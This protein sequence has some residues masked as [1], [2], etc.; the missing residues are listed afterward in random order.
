MRAGSTTARTVGG[1]V[2]LRAL[3]RQRRRLVLAG[4]SIALGV[5][6]LAGALG[7]L[8][9]IGAGLDEL[10]ATSADDADVVIEGD[11][12]YESS[13]E[14]VRRLVPSALAASAAGVDGVESVSHRLEDVALVSDEQG[15]PV[16]TPG[17]S[18]Q[19]RGTNWPE[20]PEVSNL[21]LLEGVAPS[22]DGEVLLDEH[23]AEVA[24]VGTGDTVRVAGK[25]KVG[26][27]EVSGLVASSDAGRS[28]GSS[29]V[30]LSTDEAR[31]V[32]DQPDDDNRIAIRL[33]PD[34]DFEEV[35]AALRAIAPPGTEVTDGATAAMH[36]TESLTRSFVVVRMLVTA[37]G[38]L[39]LLVGTVTVAN[40]LTLLHSQRRRMFAG[41]R[42]AGAT[43]GQ[44]RRAA[45]G[46]AVVLAAVSSVLG[47]PLGV[48]LA[49]LIE[50]ALGAL[51]SA[52]PTAGPPL[53]PAAAA[54]AV[55][56]GVLATVAAAWRP[57]ATACAVPPVEAV[58]EVP[59]VP[60]RHRHPVVRSA[61]RAIVALAAV[62]AVGLLASVEVA[63]VLAVSAA[64]AVSVFLLGFVPG[65]LT[66]TVA[67]VMRRFPFRPRPLR[68]VA[69]RD[70]RRN[71]SRTAATT[72][73]VL[74]AAAVVS[75][76]A[77]FLASF[78]DSVDEAVG[79]LV[80]ADLVVDSETFT[81]GGLP[82]DLVEQLAFVDG[83]DQAS[84]WKLGRGSV[85]EYSVRMT[86]LDA[87]AAPEVLD[88]GF[89]GPD[90]GALEVG[91]V[92]VSAQFADR[93]GVEIGDSLPVLFHSGG[94]ENLVVTGIYNS[95]EALLGD[96]VMEGSVLSAQ[97]PATNDIVALVATDG[98]ASTEAA[99][100]E[101]AE[102]YGVPSVL[103]PAEFVSARGEML[104][105]FERVILWMLLFTLL[106]ALVGVVNTL[107]LSVGERRRE[108][109]LLRVA[110]TSR[111]ALMRMVLFEGVAFSSVGTLLGILAGTGAAAVGVW[112]LGSIGFGVFTVPVWALLGIAVAAVLVG[113]AAAWFP[114][115]MAA[116]VPP[117]DAVAD[118]G[119]ESALS[120]RRRRLRR[121]VRQPA[122]TPG[123]A[124]GVRPEPVGPPPVAP[125]QAPP[126]EP[127]GAPVTPPPFDPSRLPSPV[128]L[129]AATVVEPTGPAAQPVAGGSA[130]ATGQR[131][132]VAG[133]VQPEP[134]VAQPVAIA[135][136]TAG[137]DP[138]GDQIRQTRP[139]RP[140]V[141]PGGEDVPPA[142]P[143]A[144][145]QPGPSGATPEGV[146]SP[147]VPRRAP[148]RRSRGRDTRSRRPPRRARRA[149]QGAPSEGFVSGPHAQQQP[150]APSPPLGPQDPA[151]SAPAAASAAGGVPT[152]PDS[153]VQAASRLDPGSRQAFSAVLHSMHAALADGEHVGPLVCG[154]V[155][156]ALA[157]VARTDRRLLVVVQ[158]PN[159]MAVES[160]HPLATS[161]VLRPGPGGTVVVVLVDRG[162]QLDVTDVAPSAETESLTVREALRPATG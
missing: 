119:A 49:T 146:P 65:V 54:V 157:A 43:R 15:E 82:S 50:R 21:E 73:A 109:G 66:A 150:A 14:Q 64:V 136:A 18:E 141:P 107:V 10:A 72:A 100:R 44:L 140:V 26:T 55:A 48:L 147:A 69:A 101:L 159:R 51:G 148:S 111:A 13:L 56:M 133:P 85:G 30:V 29:L 47:V 120:A 9:R 102:S 58:Q 7:L 90:P 24:G 40:S 123:P 104:R 88:L 12:A 11:V 116:A 115:R 45:L 38:V 78:T 46:E 154:R 57:V 70:A 114:A 106:Q 16:A 23:S 160:L 110:G 155:H 144:A 94:S 5:G 131:P 68:L 91:E 63:V 74:L 80:A 77:V 17:L 8:D 137:E 153:L 20:D 130:P 61:A 126:T 134:S 41:F 75:G 143:A 121:R 112:A 1:I 42:L 71:P 25:G 53:T 33:E 113:V 28:G 103:G 35:T 158:R 138:W 145:G 31:L 95:G 59:T 4:I 161:V 22:S 34:A 129:G 105:G 86:G 93:S 37:F 117:L 87:A 62:G 2:V 79:N 19:P 118:I 124:T 67:M 98:E 139:A 135:D 3:L 162:R 32:F 89:E 92:W 6:Y 60:S 127:V 125:V 132:A 149:G 52:V 156:G 142:S 39:A 128:H 151:V 122:G 84:G 96:L 76:L 81:R 27:Y 108:F 97:V 152:T 83:V 36:A 99:V